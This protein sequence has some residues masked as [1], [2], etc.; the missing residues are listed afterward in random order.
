MKVYFPFADDF[1]YSGQIEYIVYVDD[2]F[3]YNSDDKYLYGKY[4]SLDEALG[5]CKQI[6]ETF[7][8]SSYKPKMKSEELLRLYKMFGEDPY[9]IGQSFSG[10]L[11]A[12]KY[13]EK[14]CRF[15]DFF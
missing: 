8:R 1:N 13:C 7:L 9:I 14:I 6:V 15:D 5:I 10:W 3:H 11:Y 12:E 4:G 2:N